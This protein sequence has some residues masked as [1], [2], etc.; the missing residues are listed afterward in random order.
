MKKKIKILRIIT[1]LN[2]KFGGP[3]VAIIDSSKALQKNG[4]EVDIITSDEPNSKYVSEKNLKIMNLGPSFGNYN[5]N[6]KLLFWLHKNHYKYDK[7]IIHGIWQFNTLL[8]RIILK[9]GYFV[10]L[11]GQLDNFFD[12]IFKKS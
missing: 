7:F 12:R 1:S 2:P 3:P 4:F 6:L 5:F 8:S 11:H 9:Q 10:F